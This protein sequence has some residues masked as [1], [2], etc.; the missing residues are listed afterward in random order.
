MFLG[1]HEGAHHQRFTLTIELNQ[2]G[3]EDLERSR[4]FCSAMGAAP[5]SMERRDEKSREP[6]SGWLSNM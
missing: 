5:Y 6:T 4:S 3:T 1:A 2:N